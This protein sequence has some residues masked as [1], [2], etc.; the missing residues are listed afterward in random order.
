MKNDW[1]PIQEHKKGSEKENQKKI[2]FF[3]GSELVNLI[4]AR[5]LKQKEMWQEPTKKSPVEKGK[6]KLCLKSYE[7]FMFRNKFGRSNAA[8]QRE[9]K[10]TI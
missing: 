7:S 2:I 3:L 8:D 6:Q 10:N 4:E 9:R 5:A 1:L